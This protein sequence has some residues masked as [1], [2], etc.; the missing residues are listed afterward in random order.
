MARTQEN[1]TITEEEQ[2]ALQKLLRSPKMSQGL[3]SRAKIVLL[4]ALG[5]TAEDVSEQ[6]GV[7]LRTVYRWRKRF[8]D[9]GIEGLQDLPR[10][11]QPKKLSEAKVKEVLRNDGRMYPS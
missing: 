6:L 5:T 8:K 10:S 4:T 11:G 7:T 1:Y 9:S 2:Q 3:A